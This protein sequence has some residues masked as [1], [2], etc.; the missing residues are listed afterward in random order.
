M[1]PLVAAAVGPDGGRCQWGHSTGAVVAG[2][3]IENVAVD[4]MKREM[5]PM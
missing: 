1:L 4:S 5:P 2:V 3:A